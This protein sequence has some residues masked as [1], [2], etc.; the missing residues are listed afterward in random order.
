M[1]YYKARIYSPMLGRF[2]QTD[3]IAYEDNINLYTYVENDPLNDTDS[4]GLSGDCPPDT[5]CVPGYLAPPALIPPIFIPGSSE[6]TAFAR[7]AA[8]Q[9]TNAIQN[10]RDA[11]GALFNEN[12]DVT[13]P[14]SVE[15]A[16]PEEVEEAAAEKG[17]KKSDAKTGADKGTRY[18]DQSGNRGIRIMKGGGNRTGPDAGVKSSGP[19]AQIIGGPSAGKVVPLAGNSTLRR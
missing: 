13:D 16:T 14:E 8:E 4:S 6:N 9:T 17:W 3:P 15:G 18:L 5:I 7:R 2:M 10:L 19:Y 11:I 1:Y 12:I